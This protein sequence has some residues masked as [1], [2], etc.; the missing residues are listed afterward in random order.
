MYSSYG[1]C[2]ALYTFFAKQKNKTSN[3][4]NQKVNETQIQIKTKRGF[5][6]LYLIRV[7]VRGERGVITLLYLLTEGQKVHLVPIKW[8]LQCSHLEQ[9]G[10][11]DKERRKMN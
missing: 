4:I 11:R 10:I 1:P 3:I 5:V 2:E 6:L 8:T 9:R 7:M